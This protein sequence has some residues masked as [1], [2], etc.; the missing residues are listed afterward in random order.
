MTDELRGRRMV[1]FG[2]IMLMLVGAVNVLDGVVAVTNADYLKNDLLFSNLETWGWFFIV[3]GT[4]QFSVGVALFGGS[5]LA[6]WLGIVIAGLNALAQLAFQAHEPAWSLTMVVID[7]VV[8]YALVRYGTVLGRIPAVDPRHDDPYHRLPHER[9]GGPD[10]TG[11]RSGQRGG[12]P[13]RWH[14]ASARANSRLASPGVSRA[15]M[16]RH[17]RAA[18]VTCR[19]R[20][21]IRRRA[22]G[23]PHGRGSSGRLLW[24]SSSDGIFHQLSSISSS[25]PSSSTSSSTFSSTCPGPGA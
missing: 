20:A 7:V 8:I 25:V 15:G 23:H 2:A 24:G 13:Q 10:F 19:Q 3:Y 9:P 21:A 18:L 14:F 5:R 11:A 22:P 12:A 1:S 16:L 6:Q 17:R 4:F